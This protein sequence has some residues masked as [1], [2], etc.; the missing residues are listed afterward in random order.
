MGEENTSKS[1][2]IIK[3]SFKNLEEG[4]GRVPTRRKPHRD[5]AGYLTERRNSYS[6]GH[7]I[8]L[9]CRRAEAEGHALV[10]DYSEEGG[11]YQVLCNEHGYVVHCSNMDTARECMKD[12]TV[13]CGVCRDLSGNGDGTDLRWWQEQK[14]S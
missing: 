14:K 10:E 2:T 4:R 12:P 11:R 8:V 3:I 1:R 5:L 7:T 9:D 6:G 13:F